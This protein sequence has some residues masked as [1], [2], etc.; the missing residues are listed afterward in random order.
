MLLTHVAAADLNLLRVLYVLLEERHVSRAAERCFLSQPAMS[1]ALGRLRS[2]FRDELLIRRKGA[3]ERTAKGERLLIELEEVLPRLETLLRGQGFDP[4][5]SQD[6]FRLTMTD[7]ASVV[8]LPGLV[9]RVKTQAPGVRI[10]LLPWSDDRFEQVDSGRLDLVTD[11]PGIP[12]TLECQELYTDEMVCMVGSRHP[13]RGSRVRLRDYLKYPHAVVNV[14]HGQQ[15]AIDARL[16][17]LGLR[18]EAGIVVG[19][20]LAALLAIPTTQ[21]IFTVP[22]LWAKRLG[23]LVPVRTLRAPTELQGFR[24]QMAW[25]PRLTADP[26]H[27]W[28]RDQLEAVAK[29]L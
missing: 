13:L 12:A 19:S 8:L 26:A 29:A 24:Y 2:Q 5:S 18:R 25:H 9:Q 1:R 3:Y 10:E 6:R 23:S 16:T 27:R 7:H 15:T 21:M 17:E 4:A 20:F 22:G 28:F 14:L 11:I